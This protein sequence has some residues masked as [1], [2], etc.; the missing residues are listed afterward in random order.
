ML[1]VK[2]TDAVD[3]DIKQIRVNIGETAAFPL[4]GNGRIRTQ[5]V[6]RK[7]VGNMIETQITVTATDASNNTA[8]SSVTI[9][10]EK[11]LR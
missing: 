7:S 9:W 2:V 1:D 8:S 5:I 10:L 11:S 3:K 6:P 4:N